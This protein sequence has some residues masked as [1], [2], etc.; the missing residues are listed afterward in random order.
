MQVT[1]GTAGFAEQ[2]A[3]VWVWCSDLDTM[4]KPHSLPAVH[5]YVQ[6]L[7]EGPKGESF[8]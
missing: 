2:V 7:T 4:S 1:G 5:S 3:W 8:H 6:V